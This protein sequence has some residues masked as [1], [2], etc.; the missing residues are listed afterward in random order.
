MQNPILIK[1]KIIDLFVRNVKGRVPDSS[2]YTYEHDGKEGHWLETQM[3]VSHNA[4]NAPDI[5]GFEMKNNT[6]NKTT[7]GD[8]SADYYIF[9]DNTYEVFRDKKNDVNRA[10]FLEIFGSPNQKKENRYSWSGKPCPKIDIYN[11]F[12][13]ILKVDNDGNIFAI[14]SFS[15]DKRPDKVNI[16]PNYLQ[17]ENLLLANWDHISMKRKVESK[18]YKLGWFKC[19]KN[20]EGVYEN[21]VFGKPINFETWLEGVRMGFI[22]FDSGMY[23]GNLRNYSQW[24]A[25]NK[26]W[27]AMIVEKY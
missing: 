4:S 3:G 17:Q 13:Q 22:F 5:D 2:A 21:I 20:A 12:G 11:S 18:F 10:R 26:Y 24:R 16:V 19:I 9:K 14:Y 7:F 23:N 15:E 6:S 25:N 8:W 27:D 1:Q